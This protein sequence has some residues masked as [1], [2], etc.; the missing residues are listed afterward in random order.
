ML[1]RQATTPSSILLPPIVRFSLVLVV[2]SLAPGALLPSSAASGPP[3]NPVE[4]SAL[5]LDPP[6]SDPGVTLERRQGAPVQEPAASEAPPDQTAGYTG[7]YFGS[8]S[9]GGWVQ[10]D[11]STGGIGC[12][13]IHK[14][15]FGGLI[16]GGADLWFSGG[17]SLVDGVFGIA[18]P[19]GFWFGGIRCYSG[20]NSPGFR[21]KFNGTFISRSEIRFTYTMNMYEG[22][23]TGFCCDYSK[24]VS[25]YTETVILRNVGFLQFS[26]PS[27]T[28]SEIDGSVV[29]TITRVYGDYGTVSA[30]FATSQQTAY[31][32]WDYVDTKGN[33]TFRDGEVSKPI[34]IPLL[35]DAFSETDETFKVGLG[36]PQWP[37]L[38]GAPTEVTVTIKN[39]Q[40]LIVN[41]LGDAPDAQ[42]GDGEC[43]TGAA[44]ATQCTLRAAIQEAQAGK[45]PP[46]IGFDL[47]GLTSTIISP[48]SA[49]PPL[50]KPVVIDARNQP[51]ILDGSKAGAATHGLRVTGPGVQVLG[52]Q[53]RKF[54]GAGL[55]LRTN[56]ATFSGQ[57]LTLSQNGTAGIDSLDTSL[58]LDRVTSSDHDRGYGLLIRGAGDLAMFGGASK[59]LRNYFGVDASFYDAAATVSLQSLEV[60]DTKC[61]SGI[62]L[63]A[64]RLSTVNLRG[65]S[66]FRTGWGPGC[67]SVTRSAAALRTSRFAVTAEGLS[68]LDNLGDGIWVSSDRTDIRPTM[69]AQTIQVHRNGGTALQITGG[70]GL[71]IG[72]T[73]N[74]FDANGYGIR[75]GFYAGNLVSISST[76]VKNTVCGPGMQFIANDLAD[77]ALESVILRNN[78]KGNDCW[79]STNPIGGLE[80]ENF[81]LDGRNLTVEDN[82]GSGI[83]VGGA[84][85]YQ[86]PRAYLADITVRNQTGG[87]GLAM[88]GMSG[89]TLTGT[90]NRISGNTYGMSGGF[91]DRARVVIH[92]TEIRDNQCYWGMNLTAS[93]YGLATL[94]MRNVTVASNG[95]AADCP[96]G[97]EP[98]GIRAY[99]F[100]ILGQKLKVLN[101]GGDGVKTPKSVEWQGGDL[102]GNRGFGIVYGRKLRLAQ[103]NVCQNQKSGIF[104][105]SELYEGF[106]PGSTARPASI[107]HAEPGVAG[108]LIASSVIS[109]NQHDGLLVQSSGPVTV[110]G[111]SLFANGGYAINSPATPTEA[112]GN[113]WGAITGP[114]TSVAGTV[115][116]TE[117][118]T[119]PLTLTVEPAQ[120]IVTAARGVGSSTTAGIHHWQGITG[121]VSVTVTDSL[122][123]RNGP[124]LSFLALIA[125]ESATLDLNFL[126][127]NS[128]APGT[129]STVLLQVSPP[130]GGVVTNTFQVVAAR[131]IDLS[132]S[133][134]QSAETVAAGAAIT[135]TATITN[136]GIDA[137]AGTVVTA[138]IPAG[139][140]LQSARWD[141]GACTT[142]ATVVCTV[143]T[144]TTSVA[145]TLAA[146]IPQAGLYPLTV[147]AATHGELTPA[148]NIASAIAT[149]Y[150][151]QE[152][153]PGGNAELRYVDLNGHWTT[154]TLNGAVT[155]T[156]TIRLMPLANLV[157]LP[158]I[159]RRFARHDFV[160]EAFRGGTILAGFQFATPAAVSVVYGDSD[161]AGLTESRLR[162]ERWDET[163]G[164]WEDAAL[165]CSAPSAPTL[166]TGANSLTLGICRTGDF[167]LFDFAPFFQFLAL[168]GK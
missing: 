27:Y 100:D 39:S 155:E 75:G 53:I 58:S 125:G 21:L 146:T 14:T 31:G 167:A 136:R 166:Q 33:V 54:G 57:L 19:A 164:R 151:E 28:A 69:Q 78:G 153:G 85:A 138:A 8:T 116:A 112:R 102:C 48:L 91:Y 148:D 103:V 120:K 152:V 51:V 92:N 111:S 97:L 134:V 40:P 79:Q 25:Q 45:A 62:N 7:Y 46:I 118:R 90:T 132:T 141:G 84:S 30:P 145:I 47:A 6:A 127:P 137:A 13:S 157:R 159:A 115:D 124:Q 49:L 68:V 72:G 143:G 139:V 140:T 107:R 61:G 32:E 98:G 96:S 76:T 10:V 123:W 2:L 55:H 4:T 156:A 82:H 93:L 29:L 108:S 88:R 11:G 80:A 3:A 101:N 38:T 44:L 35:I 9:D 94:F 34:T 15:T 74:L 59:I 106:G 131:S 22:I 64:S 154:V 23:H 24:I 95:L 149:V 86:Q 63:A 121:T 26:A 89:L 70:G 104:S 160:L 109:A 87:T 41:V 83:S 60:S 42:P 163:A 12:V 144:L 129:T 66:V 128:A 17:G 36:I 162:L 130:G 110:T 105:T 16:P 77:L 5:D 168:I 119:S 43:S 1:R 114:G 135:W 18:E 65:V 56:R 73:S 20:G 126:P 117:W 81:H 50:E 122:G 99:N 52:L 71:T 37:T 150:V 142:G 133:L 113:W 165:T 161:V 67:P 158:T 147:F